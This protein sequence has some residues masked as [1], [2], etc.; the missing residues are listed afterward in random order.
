M[1]NTNTKIKT[2]LVG[3][4]VRD[5]ILG[6]PSKDQDYVVVGANEEYMLSKGF[7]KVGK[8]FPVFLHPETKEE[9]ALARKEIKVGAGYSGFA[10]ETENVTLK[11]DLLRRDLTINA[12][13]LDLENNEVI[14]YFGGQNDLKNKT[15]RHVSTHFSEDPVRILRVARFAARY[16]FSIAEDTKDMLK[17]MVKNGEADHLVPDRIIKEFDKAFNE[18]HL[19]RFF[20]TLEEIG[21]INKLG[22]FS[23]VLND[24][25]IL[26]KIF[27]FTE[28]PEHQKAAIYNIVFQNF[29][30]K[31][32]RDFKLEAQTIE[33]ISLFQEF[34]NA[35]CYQDMST[36]DKLKF[37]KKN[38]SLHNNSIYFRVGFFD[39]INEKITDLNKVDSD[40][41]I[42]KSFNYEDFIKDITDKKNIGKA[43]EALQQHLIENNSIR[44]NLKP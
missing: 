42:L 18:L 22:N 17:E 37:L 3:G 19:S 34:K 9:Y 35:P 14:D 10:F 36:K 5:H 33:E 15:L 26:R 21:L 32:M 11:D 20:E 44:K 30:V 1:S 13:A 16:N 7:E 23:D 28:S 38:K 41:D 8:D 25:E 6:I 40:I 27:T 4:A 29:S 2:Y 31:E 43:V 39:F 24:K 12:M